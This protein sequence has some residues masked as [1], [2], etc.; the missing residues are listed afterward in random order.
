[1]N[2]RRGDSGLVGLNTS[3][4]VL[5]LELGD[6]NT[7]RERFVASNG[8]RQAFLNNRH[9]LHETSERWWGYVEKII[10]Q[11]ARDLPGLRV[12]AYAIRLVE[13]RRDTSNSVSLSIMCD[14]AWRLALSLAADIGNWKG[15]VS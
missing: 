6:L 3:L 14:T 13:R 2:P 1:M 7:E 5:N 11:P 10:A 12:K 9:R 8:D 15:R 4:A